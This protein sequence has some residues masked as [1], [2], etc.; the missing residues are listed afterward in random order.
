MD[1]EL[2]EQLA[3]RYPEAALTRARY[4]GSMPA[5][6]VEEQAGS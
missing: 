3:G 1:F 6:Q 4:P 2:S 5:E